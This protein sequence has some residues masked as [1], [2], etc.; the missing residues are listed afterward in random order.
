M[1]SEE[2]ATEAPFLARALPPPCLLPPSVF[3]RFLQYIYS[4]YDILWL[5][6]SYS[7]S[8]LSCGDVYMY[9]IHIYIWRKIVCG[10]GPLPFSRHLL[11]KYMCD[12][13]YW[14]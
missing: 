13:Y 1:T 11:Y 9:M 7:P 10:R 6:Q 8:P 14:K 3:V 2:N 5:L 4:I 12:I